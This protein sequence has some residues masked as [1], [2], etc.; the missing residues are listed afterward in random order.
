MDKHLPETQMKI[1]LTMAFMLFATNVFAADCVTNRFGKTVCSNGQS[2]VAVN[3]NTGTVATAQKSASGVTTAQINTGAKAAYNPHTGNAAV[4]Q[5]N[6]NGVK[7][8]QTTAGGQAKTKNGVGVA[9]GPNGT[10][11]AKGVYNQGCKK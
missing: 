10:T 1:L 8:T 3:P 4:Q 2:A 7:T 9:T 5:T 6:Q 11:C